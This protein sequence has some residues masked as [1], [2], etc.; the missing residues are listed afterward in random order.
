MK[1]CLRND[2]LTIHIIKCWC[3]IP[4][5]T[6]PLPKCLKEKGETNKLPIHANLNKERSLHIYQFSLE[7]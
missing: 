7:P 4:P 2:T 3:S 5:K 6:N 1:S